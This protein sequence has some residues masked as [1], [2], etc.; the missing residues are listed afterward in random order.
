MRV[1]YTWRPDEWREAVKL[2]STRPKAYRDT[3]MLT[4]ALIGIM[5]LGAL[6][7]F[8]SDLH[9][10]PVPSLHGSIAPVVVGSAALTY[11]GWHLL[12]RTLRRRLLGDLMNTPAGEQTVT[13]AEAGWSVQSGDAAEQPSELR[14]WSE[15]QDMR[16]GS[17][18]MVAFGLDRRIVAVPVRALSVD[19]ASYVY[20]MMV[21][22][23][24]PS[25]R[26]PARALAVAGAR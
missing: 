20:R 25:P 2:I 10:L 26:R 5:S 23:L 15:L 16:T 8:F 21:R 7:D 3:P 13:L 14:A 19:E 1:R 22:K 24:K 4:Y 18:A 9:H 17:K 12:R 6:G 11:G